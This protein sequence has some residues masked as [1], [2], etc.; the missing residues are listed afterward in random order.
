MYDLSDPAHPAPLGQPYHFGERVDDIAAQGDHVFGIG[1]G[2]PIIDFSNSSAPVQVGHLSLSGE[3]ID[4]RRSLVAVMTDYQ[5]PSLVDVQDP[6]RPA[7][8][9]T[10]HP[11]VQ[12]SRGYDVALGADHAYLLTAPTATYTALSDSSSG[13]PA[14][15]RKPLTASPSGSSPHHSTSGYLT[16]MDIRD[17]ERPQEVAHAGSN[18]LEARNIALGRDLA[19]VQYDGFTVV[20]IATPEAAKEVAKLDV[21]LSQRPVPLGDVVWLFNRYDRRLAAVDVSDPPNAHLLLKRRIG[22][23]D[24]TDIAED[25]KLAYIADAALG[26]RILDVADPAAPRPV[27]QIR[28]PDLIAVDVTPTG[29]AAPRRVVTLHAGEVRVFDLTDGIPG[30]ELARVPV[31]LG[32]FAGGDGSGE[33]ALAGG[34]VLVAAGSEGLYVLGISDVAQSRVIAHVRFPP[35]ISGETDVIRTVAVAGTSAFLL[36]HSGGLYVLDVADPT[37]P[38]LV[39]QLRLAPAIGTEMTIRGGLVFLSAIKGESTLYVVDV[40]DRSA[41]RLVATANVPFGGL[42]VAFDGDVAV[43]PGYELQFVDM[44]VRAEPRFLGT[45]SYPHPDMDLYWLHTPVSVV[46]GAVL[47]GT[48]LGL[49]VYRRLAPTPTPADV[50]PTPG[51]A[52][53]TAT[54]SSTATATGTPTTIG[55]STATASA[56]PTNRVESSPTPTPIPVI[57][58]YLPEVHG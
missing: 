12:P 52:S 14:A 31:K 27:G 1:A 32:S 53:P 56:S 45:L 5:G 41:P 49:H 29:G 9:Y 26:V 11:P 18:Q 55:V 4:V 10:P 15:S 40:A 17:P 2:L 54:A 16:V 38:R 44:S 19:F 39:G 25:G 21:G 43:L 33:I 23:W 35:G 6:A 51:A 30:R 7:V 8:L 3:R 28:A 24:I 20:D 36:G 48:H 57:R 37:Q 42:A 46:G 13:K 50:T 22:M 58:V 34:S 47:V